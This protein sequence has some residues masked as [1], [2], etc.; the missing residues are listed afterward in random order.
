MP[1]PNGNPAGNGL[2]GAFSQPAAS[3]R[4]N[5]SIGRCYLMSAISLIDK[6]RSIQ[7][8]SQPW[9]FSWLATYF[10]KAISPPKPPT[11]T[12]LSCMIGGK[13]TLVVAIMTHL[14]QQ[15]A[16]LKSWD[17]FEDLCCVLFQKEW[18]TA[19]K[20]G[21]Y[22]QVQQG[23]DVFGQNR[24][25]GDQWY[26][27]ACKG[28]NT[29]FG[30][31]L[32]AREI[33]HELAK[34]DTFTPRLAHWIIA[35]TAPVDVKL[36]EY[37]HKLTSHRKA[38]GLCPVT[39]YGWG[40]I[41]TLLLKHLDVTQ[42]FYPAHFEQ[43]ASA[44]KF[45]VPQ[46]FHLSDYFSDPLHHL[47]TLRQQL[48]AQGRTA[49]PAKANLQG[50]GGVGKTQLALKYSYEFR[51]SY[52]GVWW[53]SAETQGSLESDCLLFCEK[54]GIP[55]AQN[56]APGSAVRNWLAGQENWL[57]VYDNAEDVKMV[58]PFLPQSGKH[59]VLLTS[60]NPHWD[61]MKS[62]PL[63]VWNEAQGLSFLRAR[64]GNGCGNG[65]GSD[66]SDDAVLKA[67]FNALDGLPL[68]LEQ[69]CAYI[70]ISKIPLAKYITF[71][72]QH[73]TATRL[74]KREDGS[75]CNR[76]VLAALS[77]AFDQLSEAAKALLKL[78]SWMAAEPIPA[79][80]FTEQPD[81][82]PAALRAA[83]QDELVWR[84]TLAE[85][86]KYALCQIAPLVLNDHAGNRGEEMVCLNF[87]RLTQ[88]AARVGSHSKETMLILALPEDCSMPTNWPRCKVL[89]PHVLYMADNY[90]EGCDLSVQF[91]NLLARLAT[92]LQYGPALYQTALPLFQRALAITEKAMGP[93]HR[94]TR[95]HMNNLAGLHRAMGD[96]D[97]AL[98]LLQ[99]IL[100][101]AERVH[102]SEHPE[103]ESCLNNLAML[104]RTKGNY[105]AALP[106]YKRALA[107]VEK[108]QG[109]EHPDTGSYLN[110]LAA[111]YYTM[112]E[113]AHAL[114]L[115][116]RALVIA[117]KMLGPEHPE[118]GTSLNNLG[119][120]YYA[121]GDYSNALLL[122]QRALSIAER[123]LGPEHP[124]TVTRLNNLAELYR[125]TGDYRAALPLFQRALAIA[126]KAQGPEHPETGTR[127]NNLAG[128]YE[129]TGDNEV[130]LSLYQRALAIAEK[131]QG[132]EHPETGTCLN[133]LALL[134]YTN[135]D[136]D[137]ALPL[138]QRA[139]AIAEKTQGKEHPETGTSLN[140]LALLYKSMG[141]YDAALPLYERAL[142]IAEKAQ[143][144][145]HFATVTSLNN[146]AA[147]HYA[148]G[149][150]DKA[151]SLL[152]EAL[153]RAEKS[154][155]AGH[156]STAI[157]R[158]NLA[159]LNEVMRQAE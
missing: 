87:H 148:M 34:A 81:K 145:E 154:L 25:D 143:G 4:M 13:F 115:V 49:V 132:T 29:Q 84:E 125:A 106:L 12:P 98:P 30:A 147:L 95:M 53:F 89:L 7:A 107:I 104:Y 159:Q 73:E 121:M 8:N 92:Y 85:L 116:E 42:R 38:L 16:P 14:P 131:T 136:Y 140:N 124:Y 122:C 72:A 149:K 66:V 27:V 151:Q 82:L 146:L 83:A 36:Q 71:L 57:L 23:V 32:T 139:L 54:Q 2:Y 47:P 50:M 97:A 93:E 114:P 40:D 126:E 86:E 15:I 56:E 9:A 79:F 46:G 113:Y 108:V 67:L 75:G 3:F 70:L 112:G 157:F 88:A 65:I 138:Y 144:P 64:L 133:N 100:E 120:L 96:Y 20:Y 43:I 152:Q 156:P 129:S 128:L 76:S 39:V 68:A 11:Q 158:E 26:G 111:V 37:V 69:A 135:G 99:R 63:G 155:G 91:G 102:G 51:Q 5:F 33:D 18:G 48:L 52:T 35:T 10:S 74:L 31:K 62:L 117:E 6:R 90:Q 153:A 130:A 119:Q 105:G 141:E 61:G 109:P 58:R 123:T 1:L 41:E 110:N 17:E 94:D 137:A 78:C 118:V 134:H 127:L 101:I 22:G 59:H 150:F 21:R 19:Q 55:V 45:H 103:T 142:A 80:L 77:L 28:E 44:P 24:H 60:R